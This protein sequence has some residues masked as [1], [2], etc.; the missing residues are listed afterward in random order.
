MLTLPATSALVL[1]WLGKDFYNS[2]V[3]TKYFNQLD[4]SAGEEILN[5]KYLNWP[6]FDQAMQSRKIIVQLFIKEFLEK[7]NRPTQIIS[8]GAGLDPLCLYLTS[9]HSN[10]IGFD[11]DIANLF[12]KEKLISNIYP[13]YKKQLNFVQAN[14][15]NPDEVIIKLQKS[16]WDKKNPSIVIVEGLSY[17]LTK[18]Q[19]K[20]LLSRFKSETSKLYIIFEYLKICTETNPPFDQ[21]GTEIFEGVKNQLQLPEDI[22][23]FSREEIQA[24]AQHINANKHKILCLSE[25]CSAL[26]QNN[27]IYQTK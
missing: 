1:L 20:N 5:Q 14:V 22:T 27:K 18:Q 10:L 15:S 25:C 21:I 13:K 16:G 11:V 3:C 2:S 17:Y 4:L 6:H 9:T 19:N 7:I 8:L 23:R 24:I 12:E 26:K